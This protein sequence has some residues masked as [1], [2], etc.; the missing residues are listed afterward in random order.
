MSS[1]FKIL[2]LLDSFE[3]LVIYCVFQYNFIFFIIVLLCSR[4]KEDPECCDILAKAIDS[5]GKITATHVRRKLKSMNLNPLVMQRKLKKKRVSEN[6][7]NDDII[8]KKG[9][10]IKRSKKDKKQISEDSDKELSTD[11]GSPSDDETLTQMME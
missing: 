3:C 4:Y 11:H 10:P 8:P 9:K 5:N 2:A 6:E 1:K 7:L